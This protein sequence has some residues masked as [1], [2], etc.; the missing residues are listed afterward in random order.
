MTLEKM[1]RYMEALEE[2]AHVTQLQASNGTAWCK[3]GEI[4]LHLK[5]YGESLTAYE[6]AL[7]L[8]ANNGDAYIGKGKALKL[9]GTELS[10][11]KTV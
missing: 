8:D 4:L 11:R 10:E 3:K 6:Q 2:L 7:K 1:L 5:R 9:L